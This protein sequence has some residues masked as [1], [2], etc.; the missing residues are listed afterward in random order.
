METTGKVMR[1]NQRPA[2]DA[3]IPL[4]LYFGR[5]WRGARGRALS[6]HTMKPRDTFVIAI[7]ATLILA[8]C[9]TAQSNSAFRAGKAQAKEDIANGVLA[10]EEAGFLMRF[11]EE[12]V[13]LVKQ[14]YG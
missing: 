11:D 10:I 14:R 12:Y 8:G 6:A 4:G 5:H 1:P 3:A 7:F 2:L 9:A 13:R